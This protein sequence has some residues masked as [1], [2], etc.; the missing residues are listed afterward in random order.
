[1]NKGTHCKILSYKLSN[2]AMQSYENQLL[3]PYTAHFLT[4]DAHNL[5]R[6]STSK[7]EHL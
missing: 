4:S 7:I 6:L 5:K 1:M 2:T 3:S